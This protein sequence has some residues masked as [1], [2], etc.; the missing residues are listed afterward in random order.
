MRFVRGVF[1]TFLF[2]FWKLRGIVLSRE[3]GE[4]MLG[5]GSN[6]NKDI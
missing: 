4:G 2:G 1:Y 6:V 3:F 5:R